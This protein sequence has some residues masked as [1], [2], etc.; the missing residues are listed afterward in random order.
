VRTTDEIDFL[1]KIGD[2]IKNKRLELS[3]T[4]YDLAYKANIADNL[5]GQIERAESVASII[6]IHRICKILELEITI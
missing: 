4:Q 5:I 6:T 2:Q 3:L 1:K